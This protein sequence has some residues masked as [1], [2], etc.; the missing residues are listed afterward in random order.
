MYAINNNIVDSSIIKTWNQGVCSLLISGS[1]HIVANIDGHWR[2]TWSLISEP[3]GISRG[4]RKLT[5]T[6]PREY[7]K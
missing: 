7:K 6:S 3:V 1:S 4:V 2:F 5:W